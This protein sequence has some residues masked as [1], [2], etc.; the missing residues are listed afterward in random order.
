MEEGG[1][2]VSFKTAPVHCCII[3][4]RDDI[5]VVVDRDLPAAAF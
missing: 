4:D 2:S 3:V 5:V 1:P